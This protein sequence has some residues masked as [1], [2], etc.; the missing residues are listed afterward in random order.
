MLE[1]RPTCENCNKSL[2]HDSNEAMICTFEC[3]FCMY[4][5]SLLKGVCPNCGGG[6]EKRPIRPSQ[7]LQKYQ[8]STVIVYKPVD[9]KVHLQKFNS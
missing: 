1:I 4:C 2:P 3:T 7:L 9:L 8:V 5:V 6:F